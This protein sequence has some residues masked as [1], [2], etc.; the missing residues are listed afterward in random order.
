M[1]H[2]EYSIQV[3]QMMEGC[4]LNQITY[5]TVVTK[6]L[7]SDVCVAYALHYCILSFH[8]QL[9]GISGLLSLHSCYKVNQKVGRIV[10][11]KLLLSIHI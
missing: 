3:A 7:D 11:E 8:R 6:S 2:A 9:M 4:T 10:R 5:L 1:L